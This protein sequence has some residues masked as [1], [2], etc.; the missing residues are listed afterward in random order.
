MEGHQFQRTGG[1]LGYWKSG[2]VRN[3]H[4]KIL[5]KDLG[6]E[7]SGSLVLLR[8]FHHGHMVSMRTYSPEDVEHAERIE[9][10]VI[11]SY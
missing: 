5:S 4:A 9:Q 2:V 11:V 8:I 6:R 7:N 10:D 3:P 1:K